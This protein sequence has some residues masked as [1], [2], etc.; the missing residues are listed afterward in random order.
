MIYRVSEYPAHYN[1]PSIFHFSWAVY[2]LIFSLKLSLETHFLISAVPYEGLQ[3]I[4]LR[5]Q[6]FLFSHK[7]HFEAIINAR[8]SNMLHG[9]LFTTIAVMMGDR[10]WYFHKKYSRACEKLGKIETNMQY[11]RKKRKR[12]GEPAPNEIRVSFIPE[13]Y[14][15]HF[16][17]WPNYQFTWLLMID[18][19]PMLTKYFL[20][21]TPIAAKAH[22][23]R[24]KHKVF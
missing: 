19:V 13:A 1:T 20:C 12:V 3:S 10:S 14:A 8:N 17:F 11:S 22:K 7:T 5:D 16:P 24:K 2:T 23:Y 4:T 15:F 21:F 9:E 18:Q 6:F